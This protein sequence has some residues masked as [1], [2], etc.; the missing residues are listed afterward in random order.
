MREEVNRKDRRQE[1]TVY[2]QDVG[3]RVDSNG[4]R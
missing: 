2:D 1:K 3:K 4:K